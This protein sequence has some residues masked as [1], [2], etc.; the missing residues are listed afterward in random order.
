MI[1]QK[2]TKRQW[3][4]VLFHFLLYFLTTGPL[5]ASLILQLLRVIESIA[6]FISNSSQYRTTLLSILSQII[7]NF[8]KYSNFFKLWLLLLIQMGLL[9]SGAHIFVLWFAV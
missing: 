4:M 3:L 1:D 5:S 9:F 6:C 8:S 2:P 7:M